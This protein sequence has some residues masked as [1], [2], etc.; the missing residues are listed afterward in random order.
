MK[1]PNPEMFEYVPE[2]E[3]YVSKR[4][5]VLTERVK[6]TAEKFEERQIGRHRMF[7]VWWE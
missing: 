1:R 4:G 7:M 2:V 5:M 3:Q 6:A